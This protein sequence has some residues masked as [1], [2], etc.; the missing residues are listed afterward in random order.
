[1][2]IFRSLIT[3]SLLMTLLTIVLS[4]YIR[5]AEVGVG[6]HDW[7][8]CY[9][10]LNPDLQKGITVLTEQGREMAHY[11]ARI[12]H[13]YIASTLGLFI[14]AIFVISLRQGSARA[15]GVAVP[16]AVFSITVFL[17]LLGYYTPTRSNP[18]ITMGNLL[19]GMALLGLLWW[20]L[21][22]HT[23]DVGNLTLPA[24][25]R[26]LAL[27]ALT[28]VS[29]QIV[30]GGWASANYAS[31]SCPGLVQCE[32]G[33]L[34]AD[35]AADVFNPLREIELDSTGQ[36]VRT[37]SLGLLS[38]GH[39]LFA[40]LTAGYLA[41]M[42]R[43]MKSAPPLRTSIVALSAFSIS[44]LILGVS[45]VWLELPLLMLTLHNGLAAGLLLTTINLLH[46]LTPAAG[47][48]LPG[49]PQ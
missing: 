27:L 3:L 10:Q 28:L 14:V 9:A 13:R 45:T 7:P 33:M 30:L 47:S 25:L 12:A 15:T 26:P 35:Q 46:R 40:L 44:Q 22:R 8:A 16:I 34:A 6:C 2:S 36:V 32:Q 19:G 18:M 48:P 31:A 21:L 24:R 42:V 11:G 4:A 39:R 38:M 37:E 20:Q 17:S 23:V 1:M 29:L 5:L 43:K 41:W 49:P